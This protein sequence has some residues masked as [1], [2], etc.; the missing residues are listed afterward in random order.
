VFGAEWTD[1]SPIRRTDERRATPWGRPRRRRAACAP[2]RA[3]NVAARAGHSVAGTTAGRAG[4]WC[5]R[6]HASSASGGS[7]PTERNSANGWDESSNSSASSSPP[8]PAE[9]PPQPS[10]ATVPA[11]PKSESLMV[12]PSGHVTR[13]PHFP[14]GQTAQPVAIS[15]APRRRR[16]RSEQRSVTGQPPTAARVAARLS[17]DGRVRAPVPVTRSPTPVDRSRPGIAGCVPAYTFVGCQV[18]RDQGLFRPSVALCRG[19]AGARGCSTPPS[20][21]RPAG[22]STSR[23]RSS[24]AAPWW[25][26]RRL[27]TWA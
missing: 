5:T 8:A 27:S 22:S 11:E 16:C 19:H 25:R 17:G 1:S 15:R 21:T 10:P 6:G 2:P 20:A 4:H 26:W 23:R 24:T 14:R 7:L 13:D 18:S 12:D 3:P 9:R